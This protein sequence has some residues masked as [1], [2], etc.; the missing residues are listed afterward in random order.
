MSTIKD[1]VMKVLVGVRDAWARV[2]VEVYVHLD[3]KVDVGVGTNVDVSG[4]VTSRQ[5]CAIWNVKNQN[6]DFYKI[7]IYFFA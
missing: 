1:V 6:L 5:R 2:S 7:R 4:S 3:V